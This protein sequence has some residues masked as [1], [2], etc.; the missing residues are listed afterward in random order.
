MHVFK[1]HSLILKEDYLYK[2][3]FIDNEISESK[4]FSFKEYLT[5][6]NSN[7]DNWCN[8]ISEDQY[9]ILINTI[10]EKLK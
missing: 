4:C 6:K 8:N 5:S 3:K 7:P 10:K 1:M 9:I 2:L